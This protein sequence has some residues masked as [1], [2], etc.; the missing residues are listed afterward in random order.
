MEAAVLKSAEN[1]IKQIKNCENPAKFA[2]VPLLISSQK[3]SCREKRKA[4]QHQDLGSSGTSRLALIY[5]SARMAKTCSL[6]DMTSQ[7][8]TAGDRTDGGLAPP[9]AVGFPH[10][11]LCSVLHSVRLDHRLARIV[12]QSLR[13]PVGILPADS[14][15]LSAGFHLS[16]SF[17]SL[18]TS[19]K[20]ACLRFW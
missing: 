6:N 15:G 18:V 12:N 11:R 19:Q 1:R 20:E 5:V 16:G 14:A 7:K 2:L 17:Q 9:P 3:R 10:T 4:G 8:V 13:W